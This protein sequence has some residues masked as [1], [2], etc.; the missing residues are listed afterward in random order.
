MKRMDNTNKAGDPMRV[1]EQFLLF[2]SDGRYGATVTLSKDSRG[3]QY[4]VIPRTDGTTGWA[5]TK[6]AAEKQAMDA[7]RHQF[8]TQAALAK[9]SQMRRLLG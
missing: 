2:S 8:A 4:T 3:Y 7:A 6:E 9:E 5:K 1:T